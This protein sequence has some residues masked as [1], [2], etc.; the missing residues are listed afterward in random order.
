MSGACDS[1]KK[2][3][4]LVHFHPS[5]LRHFERAQMIASDLDRSLH[6]LNEEQSTRQE[7][8]KQWVLNGIGHFTKDLASWDGSVKYE[9]GSGRLDS[10]S[11]YSG[12]LDSY[13]SCPGGAQI[14]VIKVPQ[15]L[16]SWTSV[17]SPPLCCTQTCARPSPIIASETNAI[18]P[19]QS[20]YNA[21]HGPEDNALNTNG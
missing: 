5:A 1:S 18:E 15:N 17:R 7:R 13:R 12:V 3:E 8:C 9:S 20:L 10:G 19:P 11:L 16:E 14:N 4:I 21:G 6:F 2:S